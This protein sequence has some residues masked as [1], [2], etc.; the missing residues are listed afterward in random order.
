[1]V[2]IDVPPDLRGPV[3]GVMAAGELLE[4]VIKV[5]SV[6]EI[7]VAEDYKA[8]PG[9]YDVRATRQPGNVEAVAVAATP[10]LTPQG[11]LAARIRFG[12]GA[13][14]RQGCALR[15]GPQSGEGG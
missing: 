3:S 15:R 9:E 13:S 6:P 2:P 8:M 12:A 10:E 7:A 11:K 14:R 4:A 1:M 5:A